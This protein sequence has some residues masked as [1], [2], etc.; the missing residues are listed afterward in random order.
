[1]FDLR[2]TAGIA[3][4]TLSRPEARNAIPLIGWS[5]LAAALDE[6]KAAKAR[7]LI[8]SA[9]SGS[10]FCSGAD[11]VDFPAMRE[12]AAIRASFRPAIRRALDM[13]R[14]LPMPTL[15]AVD[16]ACFGAGIALAIACDV[17]FAGAD[18]QFAITPAK[19][20]ISY[21]QEDVHRLVGLVGEGQA[22]R[23]LFGAQT[24]DGA[25]AQRIGLVER[26]FDRNLGDSIEG[27]ARAV[28]A[29]SAHS[30]ATLKRGLRLA[31]AGQAQDREQDHVFDALLASDEVAERLDAL[32][33]ARTKR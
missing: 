25:E 5:E 27:F 1:M 20:G 18:A 11:I 16:G 30:L 15:A 21:P 6:A 29:N 19:L 3:R 26:F 23:L 33:V 10:A 4:L 31:G 9:K 14:D 32:R 28:A 22:A 7:L 8:L 12:D 24:I 13:L 17:R 2:I